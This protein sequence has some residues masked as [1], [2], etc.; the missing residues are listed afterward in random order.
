[1]RPVSLFKLLLA[2][3]SSF[4][5]APGVLAYPCGS[6]LAS[7]SES[8]S[9]YCT[10]GSGADGDAHHEQQ[11]VLSVSDEGASGVLRDEE[12]SRDTIYKILKAKQG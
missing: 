4:S 5:A 7:V 12:D 10:T 2:V 11:N 6:I 9:G 3:A 1:M 8:F